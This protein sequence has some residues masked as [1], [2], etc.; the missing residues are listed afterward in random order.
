MVNI[1][2]V[3]SKVMSCGRFNSLLISE[4]NKIISTAGTNVKVEMINL[5]LRLKPNIE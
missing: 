1:D 3:I 4:E 2:N 5:K